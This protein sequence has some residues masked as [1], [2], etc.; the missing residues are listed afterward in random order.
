MLTS[1]LSRVDFLVTIIVGTRA[2]HTAECASHKEKWSITGFSFGGGD[3][4][5]PAPLR[6]LWLNRGAGSGLYSPPFVLVPFVTVLRYI[7]ILIVTL[8]TMV[9]IL[10]TLLVTERSKDGDRTQLIRKIVH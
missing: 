9:T 5:M 6:S 2:P 3:S 1:L 4:T 10:V 8:V 7:V